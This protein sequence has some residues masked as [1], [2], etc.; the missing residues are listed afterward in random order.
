M[1]SP[2]WKKFAMRTME[3]RVTGLFLS[4]RGGDPAPW[5]GLD[6]GGKGLFP[7]DGG[8]LWSP[9]DLCGPVVG[10]LRLSALR[11]CAGFRGDRK[12]G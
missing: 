11:P 7:Q 4:L 3:G 6:P 9:A 8:G 10:L 1:S 2:S 12:Q 5:R